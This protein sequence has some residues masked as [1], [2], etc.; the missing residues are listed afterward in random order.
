MKAPEMLRRVM[1]LG[2]NFLL[3]E[4]PSDL[5]WVASRAHRKQKKQSE[6]CTRELCGPEAWGKGESTSVNWEGYAWPCA[7]GRLGLE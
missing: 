4:A 1:C 2:P 3:A 7:M 6:R 5:P